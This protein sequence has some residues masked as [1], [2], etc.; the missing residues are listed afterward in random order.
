M[1]KQ[2]FKSFSEKFIGVTE[3]LPEKALILER[4]KNDRP[5]WI[6]VDFVTGKTA[7]VRKPVSV[8]ADFP[9]LDSA[10]LDFADAKIKASP[11]AKDAGPVAFAA[12]DISVEGLK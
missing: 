10:V 1:G 5:A 3:V 8:K 4:I 2:D 12:A 6:V 7:L 9:A 11:I